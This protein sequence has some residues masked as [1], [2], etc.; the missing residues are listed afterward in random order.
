MTRH[1]SRSSGRLLALLLASCIAASGVVAQP[2]PKY[3]PDAISGTLP[4]LAR[5][6]V[7]VPADGALANFNAAVAP[8]REPLRDVASQGVNRKAEVM[9]G[10]VRQATKPAYDAGSAAVAR[11]V[12]FIEG[13]GYSMSGPIRKAVGDVIV[14][15][16]Q[17]VEGP[18]SNGTTEPDPRADFI[19][20]VA[21]AMGRKTLLPG[22]GRAVSIGLFGLIPKP[23]A[24][25]ETRD[26]RR[27]TDPIF[28]SDLAID[29]SLQPSGEKHGA[30]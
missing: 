28:P 3:L 4:D 10:P 16:A 18:P 22:L 1:K 5:S 21:A 29:K 11:A 25:N 14:A 2:P 26:P 15:K 17:A 19:S 9:E 30:A 7:G 6:A 20:P 12:E 27:P 8:V 24:V 23:P 13:P